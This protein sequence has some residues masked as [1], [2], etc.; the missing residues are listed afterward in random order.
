MPPPMP[1]LIDAL[2]TGTI[3]PG[4]APG[5]GDS[6]IAKR[7][8]TGPRRVGFMGIEG[9]AQADLTVHGGCDKAIHH[10]P[11]D[12]YAGWASLIGDHGLLR[13]AGAFGENISTSGMTEESVCLGDRYRMGS[14]LVEVAQGR[15]PCW[16]QAH[17]LGV[18]KMVALMVASGRT[19]WYYRVIEE[20]AVAAGD[21]L[22][23]EDRPC[24]EWPVAR[25]FALLIGGKHRG[26]S[27]AL[28][29]L[30]E[31]PLLA[32]EWRKRAK[33]LAGPARRR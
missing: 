22:V 24:P 30:G 33:G 13:Q 6:A 1:F 17:Y 7:A 2:L 23:L 25:L 27:A 3:D 16:K 8:V 18:P 4:F 32:D 12:H 20:G 26:E 28:A 19:G 11:R 21:A 9:D 10:Y 14:A 31:H 5:R 29:K 15:Q